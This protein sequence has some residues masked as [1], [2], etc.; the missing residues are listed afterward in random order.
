MPAT[1][2]FHYSSIDTAG[3][4]TRGT[5]EAANESA[6]HAVNAIIDHYLT[7]PTTRGQT[8]RRAAPGARASP[9]VLD[10]PGQGTLTGSPDF[11]MTPLGE[12]CRIWDPEKHELPELASLRELDAKLFA[13][14]LPH[15]WDMLGLEPLA[16]PLMSQLESTGGLEA[17]RSLLNSVRTS[18]EQLLGVRHG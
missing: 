1:K 17:L 2:T 7:R 12:Y 15:V 5:V 14:G 11:R 6:R 3:K 9:V 4:K 10:Y 13:A 18:L 8:P 16:L